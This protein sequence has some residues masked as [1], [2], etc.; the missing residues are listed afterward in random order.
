MGAGT[1]A[2]SVPLKWKRALPAEGWVAEA[3]L[4]LG[5]GRGVQVEAGREEVVDVEGFSLQGVL[6]LLCIL[7]HL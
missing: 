7:L 6:L 1:E 2:G 4:G 3:F 5:C